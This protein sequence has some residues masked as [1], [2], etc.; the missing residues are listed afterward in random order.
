MTSYAFSASDIWVFI[1]PSRYFD[2]RMTSYKVFLLILDLES[3]NTPH[4]KFEQGQANI[5]TNM[6]V[7]SLFCPATHS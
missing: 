1:L 2:V 3:E 5:L 6:Q 7:S 4:T